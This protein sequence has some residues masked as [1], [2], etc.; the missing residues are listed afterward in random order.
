MSRCDLL[1]CL[2]RH[3]T[4]DLRVGRMQAM[5]EVKTSRRG[6]LVMMASHC[7]CQTSSAVVLRKMGRQRRRGRTTVTTLSHRSTDGG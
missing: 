5:L 2:G 4:V 6:R 3:M 7:T 1:L